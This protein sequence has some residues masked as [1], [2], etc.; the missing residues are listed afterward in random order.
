MLAGILGTFLDLLH[1][2]NCTSFVLNENVNTFMMVF[3]N[4]LENSVQILVTNHAL[5]KQIFTIVQ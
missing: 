3:G 4:F 2:F 1:V 5:L